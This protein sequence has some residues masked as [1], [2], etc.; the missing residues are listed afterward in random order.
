ML[1]YWK[2]I[3][4]CYPSKTRISII[5]YRVFHLKGLEELINLLLPGH[6]R[7][8]VIIKLFSYGWVG[9]AVQLV[10]VI[11]NKAGEQQ[12]HGFTTVRAYLTHLLDSLWRGQGTTGTFSNPPVVFL[13]GGN[14]ANT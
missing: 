11:T 4:I 1:L 13:C 2:D 8:G 5:R 3:L 12:G 7:G 6:D 14:V 10:A 9:F